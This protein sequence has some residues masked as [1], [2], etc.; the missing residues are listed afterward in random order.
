ML[1]FD[2][3]E[4]PS[5]CKKRLVKFK[6]KTGRKRTVRHFQRKCVT[7]I[8]I[9]RLFEDIFSEMEALKGN[10]R[11]HQRL[12]GLKTFSMELLAFFN[13]FEAFLN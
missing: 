3:S 11:L 9:T 7:F 6:K 8:K 4:G 5:K 12:R 1:I 10:L 2:T 13:E